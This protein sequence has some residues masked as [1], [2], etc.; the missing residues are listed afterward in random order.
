MKHIVTYA[1]GTNKNGI[2]FARQ[3]HDKEPE[4]CAFLRLLSK[5]R[6]QFY[7]DI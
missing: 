2:S 3:L 5:Q 7:G 6:N 1:V 4:I